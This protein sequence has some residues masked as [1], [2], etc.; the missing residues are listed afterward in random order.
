MKETSTTRP[1]TR[2]II[3]TIVSGYGVLNRRLWVL[4]IPFLLDLNLWLSPQLSFGPFLRLFRDWLDRLVTIPG[5]SPELQERFIVEFINTDMRNAVAWCN[6]VPLVMPQLFGP[7]SAVS[8]P[9]TVLGNPLAILIFI[10]A[11]NSMSLLVSSVYLTGL[12]GGL[13]N[14]QRFLGGLIRQSFFTLLRLFGVVVIVLGLAVPLS[15]PLVALLL[16]LGTII[17]ELVPLIALL[18]FGAAFWIW[19][20]LG[21]AP[22]AV[23]INQAN[24]LQ[25]LWQSSQLVRANLFETLGLLLVTFIIVAG[26]GLVW[27]LFAG[28]VLG[29][30]LVIAGA[31]YLHSGLVGARL[32]FFAER[33]GNEHRHAAL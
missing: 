30:F 8:G 3:E 17:P 20:Y 11:I 15:L 26:L 12:A 21:F 33:A 18:W 27:R 4:I 23:V 29:L 16:L 25:A 10:V 13:H 24:P 31:A 6:R 1:P 28:S 5:T 19:I 32:V 7:G 9:V 2:S 14:E 22:E